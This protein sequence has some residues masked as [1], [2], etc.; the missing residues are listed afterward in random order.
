M[1]DEVLE[2]Q[3]VAVP[4]D[5]GDKPSALRALAALLA[6]DGLEADLVERV[7]VERESLA[8]TGIGGGVAI[9]HGRIPGLDGVHA[10]LGI[11]PGGLDFDA[12]DGE[13]VHIFVA[14]LAPE[15]Q[16]S[17]HLKTLAEISRRLRQDDVRRALLLASSAESARALLL[18]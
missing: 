14:V 3:R 4:L 6:G 5:A 12:V 15:S 2:A 18:G 11:H 10:A 1:L 17:L 16:P 7:F 8:S 13:P 9:P